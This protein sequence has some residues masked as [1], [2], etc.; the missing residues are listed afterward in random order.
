MV[1]N[2]LGGYL[3]TD[4]LLKK[5][6]SNV[7]LLTGDLNLSTCFD[8]MQGYKEAL[9]EH[10]Y[11]F[12]ESLVHE[13]KVSH[14]AGVQFM[15]NLLSKPFEIRS[16]FAANDLLALGAMR[17]LMNHGKRI[18]EDFAIVGYDNIPTSHLVVPSLTTIDQP[19][20]L[21]GKRAGELLLKKMKNQTE[22]VEEED[23]VEQIVLDPELIVRESA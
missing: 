21:M 17:S 10:G 6:R 16:V 12:D 14:E 15:D 4:H 22:Q 13:C 9:K 7:L 2:V 20:Y 8:R 23:Q 5:N 19:K 1:N 3:A 18:P 11:E